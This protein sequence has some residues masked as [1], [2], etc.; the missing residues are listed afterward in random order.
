VTDDEDAQEAA[1][2]FPPG[3]EGL[4]AEI[5]R[6]ASYQRRSEDIREHVAH[7][8]DQAMPFVHEARRALDQVHGDT[9]A[10]GGRIRDA[11]SAVS[12]QAAVM[13]S[14]TGALTIGRTVYATA[15][16]T[17]EGTVIADGSVLPSQ[18]AV[19][20]SDEGA[21]VDSLEVQKSRSVLDRL[22]PAYIFYIILIWLIVA[23]VGVVI[24]RFN[25]PPD[26]VEQL[27]TDPN[28][29]SL[30]LDLT[31]LLVAYRKRKLL[32]LLAVG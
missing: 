10:L 31:I 16:L 8:T 12:S 30:A 14:G 2:E 15:T 9:D 32:E 23:G 4:N 28:Y 13:L 22:P 18:N 17:G 27:Q 5:E 20:L 24:E 1:G 29:A 26:V 11:L 6:L 3:L 19:A 21:A 25:L 7:I